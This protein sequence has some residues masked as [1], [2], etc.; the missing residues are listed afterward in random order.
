MESATNAEKD[1]EKANNSDN[2]SVSSGSVNVLKVTNGVE[3]VASSYSKSSAKSEDEEEVD[4]ETSE[5]IDDAEAEITGGLQ[6]YEL[7][8]LDK[9]RFKNMVNR[10][11]SSIT[12][13]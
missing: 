3:K 4:N 5:K 2:S 13:T 9:I 8:Q 11:A 1:T 10:H 12:L 7:T 6:L